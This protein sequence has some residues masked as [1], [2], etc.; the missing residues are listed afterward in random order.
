MSWDFD[1]FAA[2]PEQLE[3]Y[4]ATMFQQL[5]VP[6]AFKISDAALHAFVTAVR[7]KYRDNPFHNF[8]HAFSVL[9]ATF[10][11]L[12]HTQVGSML[13]KLDVFATM[14]AAFCHDIDHPGHNNAYE[15]NSVSELALRHN[16]DAVL[17]RHHAHTA[18]TVILS[19]SCD[20]F[21]NLSWEDRVAARKLVSRCFFPVCRLFASAPTM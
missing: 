2:T 13:T 7:G 10:M 12:I 5:N 17:E 3:C 11:M 6:H 18:F 14:V 8:Y 20:L 15:V 9:H 1:C 16:D 19:K 4:V 21:G